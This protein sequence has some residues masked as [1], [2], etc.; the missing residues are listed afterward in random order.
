MYPTIFRYPE[1]FRSGAVIGVFCGAILFSPWN[2]LIP[3]W[4]LFSAFAL[5]GLVFSYDQMDRD[6]KEGTP[7]VRAYLE[8]FLF[9]GIMVFVLIDLIIKANS[10]VATIILSLII[11]AFLYKRML[12]KKPV[13]SR[14][15]P[16]KEIDLSRI[17]LRARLARIRKSSKRFDEE[18]KRGEELWHRFK[19]PDDSPPPAA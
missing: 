8:G 1:C 4:F 16:E 5:F 11:S 10:L 17:E 9:F 13:K 19:E 6:S 7:K 2:M 12:S 14:K 18:A 3:K 15:L